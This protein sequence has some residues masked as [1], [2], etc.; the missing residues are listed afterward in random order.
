MDSEQSYSIRS[1]APKSF[2]SSTPANILLP[3]LDTGILGIRLPGATYN[4]GR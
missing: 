2:R 3:G 1:I 4:D